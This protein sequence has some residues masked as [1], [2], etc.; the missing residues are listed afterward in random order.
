MGSHQHLDT[1][2]WETALAGVEAAD[3]IEIDDFT[4]LP[5]PPRPCPFCTELEITGSHD[6]ACLLYRRKGGR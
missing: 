3:N 5:L 6:T 2:P 4:G 1:D